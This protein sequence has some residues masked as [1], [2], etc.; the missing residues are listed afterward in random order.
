MHPPISQAHRLPPIETLEAG[1]CP[2]STNKE[3]GG[4]S[5]VGGGSERAGCI[6]RT[7]I[8]GVGAISIVFVSLYKLTLPPTTGALKATQASDMPSTASDSC[9]M[10]SG[11]SGFPKFKQLTTARGWAPTQAIFITASATTILVPSRGST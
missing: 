3:S 10:T 7:P 4:K 8:T 6:P 9:H 11:C 1:S 2:S 5:T